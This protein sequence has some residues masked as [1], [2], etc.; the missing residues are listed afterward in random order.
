MTAA[1]EDEVVVTSRRAPLHVLYEATS[2]DRAADVRG[3]HM[4]PELR[5]RYG[6][7]LLIPLRNDRPTVIANFV[8]TLDGIVAFGGGDLSGGGLISGFHEPDR[9]VMGLLRALADVVVVGAGTLRGSTEHR[10]V[11]EHVHPAS[12]EA[13]ATWRSAM[14]L[15]PRPTTLFVTASGDIPLAHAG[16]RDRTIP[17]VIATTPAGAARLSKGALDDHVSIEAVG[18]SDR[19]SGKDLVALGARLGA[20]LMLTEGGPHL[21]GEVVAA[22]LL[23]EL[24]LTLAP[25]LVGRSAPGRLG[26]V[27]GIALSPSEARWQDL[28][29][30]RRSDHHLFLR[31]RSR[32][33]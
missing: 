18:T 24:F 25:Q 6:G 30:V 8:S 2:V 7:D 9:F 16:L 31:Y 22:D 33:A 11:A 21:L 12:A 26:L 13:F 27:E 28:V 32:E 19:V 3:Q 15:A 14:G 23:D 5:E 20:R 4:P 29:T 10:W 1:T 17:V